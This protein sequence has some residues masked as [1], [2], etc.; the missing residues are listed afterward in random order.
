MKVA[1]RDVSFILQ[2]PATTTLAESVAHLRKL[3]PDS[4]II[5]STWVDADVHAGLTADRIVRSIDPGALP[6]IRAN[7]PAGNNANRQIASTA[8]G[9]RASTRPFAVKM[10][11]DCSLQD[12]R[13]LDLYAQ[14]TAAKE[15]RILVCSLFTIDPRMFE[16]MP[17]HVSDWF[18]FGPRDDLVSYWSAPFMTLEDATHY[19]RHAYAPHSSPL[20]RTMLPRLAVEQHVACHHA[21]ALGYAV[22]RFHN[23]L[24]PAVLAAHD[25]YLRDRV[26]LAEPGQI[27][28]DFPKYAWAV[29]SRFERAKCITHAEWLH[30]QTALPSG[31]TPISPWKA[32]L[33]RAYRWS[34]PLYPLLAISGVRALARR[35]ILGREATR[36][37]AAARSEAAQS[38]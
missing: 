15:T 21:A 23:D 28:L 30:M 14:H 31:L 20:D 35:L 26:V 13:F 5:V 32:W 19:A 7:Q 34:R 2:G 6:G 38:R 12:L 4:E 27:G 24:T 1:T 22:P 11:T 8:A 18:Q 3:A 25:R 37:A 9:L 33:R 36:R 29:D 17:F 10:R 16:Q